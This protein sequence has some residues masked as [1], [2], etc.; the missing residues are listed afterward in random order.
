ME[1]Q[2]NYQTSDNQNSGRWWDPKNLSTPEDLTGLHPER[3]LYPS[4]AFSLAALRRSS[5][6]RAP[7]SDLRAMTNYS[8]RP[9]I[10][11]F[12]HLSPPT[13]N[14]VRSFQCDGS[15]PLFFS[16]LSLLPGVQRNTDIK[17]KGSSDRGDEVIECI[18]V[19]HVFSFRTFLLEEAPRRLHQP[20]LLI[21]QS[22]HCYHLSLSVCPPFFPTLLF[23]IVLHPMLC[24]R[25]FS[26]PYVTL[27]YGNLSCIT[28]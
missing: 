6:F 20:A 28:T 9:S 16:F 15:K 21:I 12:F 1:S 11:P 23:I 13:W 2:N 4:L 8:S 24:L 18:M 10:N 19:G 3:A 26:W 7:S 17:A 27:C 22:S 5:D 14:A 25:F